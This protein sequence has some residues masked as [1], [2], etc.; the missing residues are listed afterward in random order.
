MEKYNWNAQMRARTGYVL[1]V[2]TLALIAVIGRQAYLQ[3]VRSEFYVDRARGQQLQNTIVRSNRGDI[4]DRNG[5]AL[6]TSSEWRSVGIRPWQVNDKQFTAQLLGEMLNVDS[7]QLYSDMV[8]YNEQYFYAKR[9]ASDKERESIQNWRDMTKAKIRQYDRSYD[10]DPLPGVEVGAEVGGKRFYPQGRLASHLLGFVS[11]D[12]K[13]IEGVECSYDDILAGQTGETIEGI[14]VYHLPVTGRQLERKRAVKGLNVV[15]TIDTTIQYIVENSLRKAVQ[16]RHAKG[17]IC[18]VMDAR[19]GEVL[20]SAVCPDFDPVNF[21]KVDKSVRRNRAVTDAYEPGSVFKTFTAAAALKNGIKPN[22]VFSCPS[23]MT[24]D[25]CT[26]GNATD[27]LYTKG[28]ETLADIIHFSFN[29]GTGVIAMQLGREKLGQTLRDFGFGDYTNCGLRGETDGIVGN[30]KDWS[31]I[32]TVTRSYGQA[33]TATPIQLC[34]AMQAISN[35]GV[36]M[37]PR[38]IKSIVDDEGN[39]VKDFPIK[40]L[41]RPI[42]PANARDLIGILEGVVSVGTGKHA[43]VPGYLVAGKTGTADVPENGVYVD[44]RHNASFL[45]IAPA[46]DPRIVV[47]IKIEDPTPVY[48]GGIVAGPV[49]SDVCSK[50][51]PYLGVS[52]KPGFNQVQNN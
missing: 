22:D 32:D 7:V 26:I 34:S 30:Y 28:V 12:E 48:F 2:F 50:I 10:G 47:L 35:G 37:Q 14:D 25:G 33:A 5:K 18:M 6:A 46:D 29:T 1:L 27:G 8:K 38:F 42:S 40:E 49:F 21:D 51:L 9:L 43:A 3:F 11:D 44:G 52:P 24:I 20:A 41:S 23:S 31:N 19:T 13:G 36:R 16:A 39:V 15:L 45:G 17:G 4:R